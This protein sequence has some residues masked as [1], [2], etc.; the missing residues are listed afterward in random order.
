MLVCGV[1]L[2]GGAGSAL[3]APS[4]S[5]QPSR[6]SGVAPL[7]VHF[8]ATGTTASGLDAF[9]QLSYDWDFGDSN[10]GTWQVSGLPKN[11]ALGP[12]AAHV[13]ETPGTFTAQVSV[14]DPSGG[15]SSKSVTIS[16]ADP[17][18]VYAGTNTTCVSASGNFTGCPSG[19][20]QMTSGSF[21]TAFGYAG[22]GQRVLLR[23]GETFTAGSLSA[24]R[25]GPVTIGAYPA[26]GTPP[27]VR[28]GSP[29]STFKFSGSPELFDD[30][31]LMD[32]DFEGPGVSGSRLITANGQIRS[33]LLLRVSAEFFHTALSI[34]HGPAS[35]MHENIFVVDSTIARMR[36]GSGG[37]GGYM[38]GNRGAFLGSRFED[39]TQAEHV[40]RLPYQ[41]WTVVSHNL[42]ANAPTGKHV[43]KIHSLGET[44][45]HPFP[46]RRSHDYVISDNQ[47]VGGANG[48][49]VTIGPQNSNEDERVYRVL[50]E[51][52]LFRSGPQGN[53]TLMLWASDA[54]VRNNVFDLSASAGGDGIVIARRGIEPPPV[55][56]EVN[57]NT[58]YSAS[59]SVNCSSFAAGSGHVSLNNLAI[60]AAGSSA[61]G[62][63]GGGNL[64]TTTPPWTA[65]SPVR[66]A[67][68]RTDPSRASALVDTGSA[69]AVAA[70]DPLG[71]AQP[72]DGNGDN[73]A[74]WDIGAFE[75]GTAGGGGGTI[76]PP[77]PPSPTAPAAPVLL[78]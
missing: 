15:V 9:R 27:L 4:V 46:E 1:L 52:N 6:T 34:S 78:P 19:A 12:V 30:W 3:A 20:R 66:L 62:I 61:S 55:N 25:G 57:N 29:S 69:V 37:N 5:L 28:A 51:R 54:T 13:Y 35:A 44:E 72:F 59:G 74:R 17:N 53:V 14:R 45:V 2:L 41:G 38:S 75:V 47:F 64:V 23:R 31:R 11:D 32:I 63:A 7:A 49:D 56:G 24:N 73:I 39:S 22:T 8:D 50:I 65:T 42:F 16:V 10:A 33:L 40:L 68:Y 36:G 71:V 76:P 26:T 67:D 21:D 43:L 18:T 77:P 58:C 60:G 70:F 48:W